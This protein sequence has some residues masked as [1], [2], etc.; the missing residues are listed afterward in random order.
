M[1]RTN[2]LDFR[3]CNLCGKRFPTVHSM[4]DVIDPMDLMTRKLDNYCPECKKRL[5]EEKRKQSGR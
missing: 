3:K 2:I 4:G 5:R 1:V